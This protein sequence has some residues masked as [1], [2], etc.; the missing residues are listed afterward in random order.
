MAKW[1]FMSEINQIVYLTQSSYQVCSLPLHLHIIRTS[2]LYHV[3]K[4]IKSVTYGYETHIIDL[5]ERFIWLCK[6]ETLQC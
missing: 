5:T 3:S 4:P 6:D 1:L 2:S